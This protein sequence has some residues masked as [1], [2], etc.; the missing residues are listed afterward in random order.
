MTLDVDASSNRVQPP[1][2]ADAVLRLF[3]RPRDAETVS[4]DLI[5]EYRES[6]RPAVGRWR[7]DLWFIRQVCGY[8]GPAV[9]VWGLL[10]AAAGQI[11]QAFDWFAPPAHFEYYTRSAITTWTAISLMVLVGFTAAWRS[12]S[13]RA[14]AVAGIVTLV[15]S[16][17]I[18]HV[19]TAAMLAIWHD[20]ETLFNIQMSGGLE[21]SFVLPL[22][23][24]IPGTVLAIA[25]AIVAKGIRRVLRQA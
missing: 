2:W 25:G 6:V 20:K 8:M 5:E 7:A 1:R 16:S 24:M 15:M 14:G 9:W 22:F 18:G 21:E 13:V 4:G 3:L 23:V 17:V 19:G 12:R 10:L 11:R